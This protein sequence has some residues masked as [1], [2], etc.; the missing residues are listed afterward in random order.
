VTDPWSPA[1]A[2][3]QASRSWR[4]VAAWREDPAGTAQKA[5]ED[6]EVL[7]AERPE[8]LVGAAFVGGALTAFILRRLAR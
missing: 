3:G 7:T 4:D 6:L 8:T 2:N 5:R 1:A